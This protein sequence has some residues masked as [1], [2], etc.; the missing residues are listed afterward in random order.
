MPAQ[1]LH[2]DRM[3]RAKPWHAF[4]HMADDLADALLH[5]ARRLVGERHGQNFARPGATG[6]ENVGNAHGEDTCLAGT[7]ACQHQH[8]PVQ[9]LD[10]EPL[11]RVE[12]GEVGG[13]TGR[14]RPRPGGNATGNGARRIGRLESLSQ[15][16]SQ[17]SAQKR[18]NS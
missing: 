9:R 13:G 15:G 16:V 7:G 1:N 8:R 4:D 10:R 14:S 3:K 6:R 12:A 17:G 2:A 18:E 5:L 11:L